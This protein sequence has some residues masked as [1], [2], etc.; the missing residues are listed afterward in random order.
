MPPS[1]R[2]SNSFPRHS[3]GAPV[4]RLESLIRA[5]GSS[6]LGEP[7]SLPKQSRH[8]L[9]Q[10]RPA[11]AGNRRFRP[12]LP[13]TRFAWAAVR[14]G[15]V[16]WRRDRGNPG[17]GRRI[18][19]VASLLR[20]DGYGETVA[21]WTAPLR[22]SPRYSERSLRHSEGAPWRDRGNPGP[23]GSGKVKRKVKSENILL[24]HSEERSD[25][26]IRN[27]HILHLHF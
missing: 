10:A 18:A 1:L 20:N 9:R 5:V 17:P 25:V 23:G 22:I 13:P 2:T 14:S 7:T 6:P 21:P 3:E 27:P 15:L 24:R 12:A 26:G 8:C 4:P 19:A 16:A 11:R